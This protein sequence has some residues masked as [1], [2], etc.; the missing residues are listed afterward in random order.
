MLLPLITR[1]GDVLAPLDTYY[2]TVSE[3]DYVAVPC[4]IRLP[5][6]EGIILNLRNHVMWVHNGWIV[7]CP[8]QVPYGALMP[9]TIRSSRDVRA[10]Y[11]WATNRPGQLV[12]ARL[13]LR[14]VTRDDEGYVQCL[15]R[16]HQ[17]I[18]EWIVQTTVLQV[19]P[20]NST[21]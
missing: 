7:R 13:R 11:E 16:P 3:G 2:L 15:F 10:D 20:K 21:Q 19:L 6:P 14:A 4:H 18:H 8:A 12:Y 1:R 9:S 5:L 17:G